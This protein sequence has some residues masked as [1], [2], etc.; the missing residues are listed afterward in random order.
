MIALSR[1]RLVR[2]LRDVTDPGDWRGVRYGLFTVLSLAVT[3]VLAGWWG[4]T[5]ILGSALAGLTRS[6]L[7]VLGLGVGRVGLA[8]IPSCW[9]AAFQ[10]WER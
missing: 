8:L 1:W 10:A 2:V 3:G 9:Q 4:L 5:A 6:D 7:G